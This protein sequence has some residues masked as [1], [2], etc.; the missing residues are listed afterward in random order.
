MLLLLKYFNNLK[1]HKRKK[2]NNPQT[3]DSQLIL[4]FHME[5][6]LPNLQTIDFKYLKNKAT[7]PSP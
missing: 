6:V 4:H 2:L 3:S 7:S 1:Q 5:W